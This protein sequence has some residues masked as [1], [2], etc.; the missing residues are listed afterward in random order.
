MPKALQYLATTS[1][2]KPP[3]TA[4]PLLGLVID[5]ALHLRPRK[6]QPADYG[7]Q[8]V[9]SAKDLILKYYRENILA[10]RQALPSH[11]LVSLV[12]RQAE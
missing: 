8:I 4:A 11:T 10:S 6:K 1:D 9:I 5:V 3:T 12:S 2:V 7:K